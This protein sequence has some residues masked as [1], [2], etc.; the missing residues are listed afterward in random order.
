MAGSTETAR[1][2]IVDEFLG[3]HK[4]WKH[5][6]LEDVQEALD[7]DEEDDL[8]FQQ[9]FMTMVA[10]ECAKEA[11]KE[12]HHI[13]VTCPTNEMIEAVFSEFPEKIMT[14][15]LGQEDEADGFDFII[16]TKIPMNESCK[17]LDEIVQGAPA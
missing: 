3:A 7:Q 15:Y 16:D 17:L 9:S 6:P 14:V 13:L 1:A 4:D 8:G 2:M 5:L 10:C 12:G 11:Q